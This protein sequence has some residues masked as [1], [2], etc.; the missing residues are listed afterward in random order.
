MSAGFFGRKRPSTERSI[1]AFNY[2]K[3]LSRTAENSAPFPSAP[4]VFQAP[5]ALAKRRH[6]SLRH[7]PVSHRDR[8]TYRDVGEPY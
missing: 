1:A 2:R 6:S 8:V 5:S 7:L 4:I 3:P